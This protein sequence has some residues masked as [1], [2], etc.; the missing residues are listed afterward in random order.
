MLL[1]TISAYGDYNDESC[2]LGL[3]Q[4]YEFD[5][6]LMHSEH[7]MFG[8]MYLSEINRKQTLKQTSFSNPFLNEDEI[9]H[10]IIR[11]SAAH[12]I[13]AAMIK[14]IFNKRGISIS[15]H[16]D[17]K[18]NDALIQLINDLRFGE[19]VESFTKD[20]LKS[21][22]SCLSKN[23]SE[24]EII[25]MYGTAYNSYRKIYCGYKMDVFFEG[26][27]LIEKTVMLFEDTDETWNV[28]TNNKNL[29]RKARLLA[30]KYNNQDSMVLFT[31][32]QVD[33]IR[34]SHS[35]N[36]R[37]QGIQ[38][39]QDM[40]KYPRMPMLYCKTDIKEKNIS[41][42]PLLDIIQRMNDDGDNT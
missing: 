30:E 34:Y 28:C 20:K 15:F 23:Q 25:L 7:N 1:N 42:T 39:V 2:G 33:V 9:C 18:Y 4:G 13:D 31:S 36:G 40:N 21:I 32:E 16:V 12:N 11:I 10:L 27:C 6:T 3:E 37:Q 22:V 17:E 26:E 19:I 5:L 24:K 29:K 8:A 41:N 35:E 38:A 14:H